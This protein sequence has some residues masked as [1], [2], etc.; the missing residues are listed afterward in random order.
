MKLDGDSSQQRSFCGTFL[1]FLLVVL[2]VTFASSRLISIHT[3][4]ED[5]IYSALLENEIDFNYKFGTEKGFF[6]AAALTMYD[7][8]RSVTEDKSYGE[9]VFE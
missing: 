4:E 3:M 2:V 6:V 1:S 7:S 9:L 8:D 5:E